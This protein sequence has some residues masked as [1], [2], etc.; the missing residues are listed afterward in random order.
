MPKHNAAYENILWAVLFLAMSWAFISFT[1]DDSFISFRYAQNLVAHGIWNWNPDHDYVEAYTSTLYTLLAIL[2][3]AL[4]IPVIAFFKAVGLGLFLWFLWRVYSF[5]QTRS[6]RAVYLLFL[7]THPY[8]Y[9]HFYSCLET[10]LFIVL[11]TELFWFLIGHHARA[12]RFYVLLL[13][14]PLTRPEGLLLSA[15]AFGYYAWQMRGRLPRPW[16]LASMI[17]IGAMYFSLRWWYFGYPLPNTYYAKSLASTDWTLLAKRLLQNIGYL[18]FFVTVVMMCR[19][20]RLGFIC[21]SSVLVYGIAYMPS[22]LV[23]NYADRFTMQLFLPVLA[24]SAYYVRHLPGRYLAVVG[25]FL[26]LLSASSINPHHTQWAFSYRGHE[27]YSNNEFGKRL[28]PY[29]GKYML[30]TGESG[31]IPYYS[32]WKSYDLMGLADRSIAHH[33]FSVAYVKH[34]RPDMLMLYATIGEDGAYKLDDYYGHE[35]IFEFI[36]E[37]GGYALAAPLHYRPCCLNLVFLKKDI[38]DYEAIRQAVLHASVVSEFKSGLSAWELG[39]PK[40]EY[41]K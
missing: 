20:A 29:A 2:P 1:V 27:Y 28:S 17:T 6:T 21:L 8:V 11:A 39:G 37:D 4:G 25:S 36:Q 3:H 38:P 23:M 35:K 18:M 14:L 9:I 16:L 31:A 33:G 34:I 22:T 30:M 7:L 15:L 41:F 5:C 24:V 32:G 10:G 40:P 12:R 26:L 13:L 19:N